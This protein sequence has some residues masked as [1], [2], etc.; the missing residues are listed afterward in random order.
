M[1]SC[2]LFTSYTKL[3]HVFNRNSFQPI[4]ISKK[5][6]LCFKCTQIKIIKIVNECFVSF[7]G[8]LCGLF[9]SDWC[10]W[11]FNLRMISYTLFM[12]DNMSLLSNSLNWNAI[13]SFRVKYL[14][15]IKNTQYIFSTTFA[16]HT[17]LLLLFLS[18]LFFFL[19]FSLVSFYVIRNILEL[20]NVFNGLNICTST[21]SFNLISFWMKWLQQYNLSNKFNRKMKTISIFF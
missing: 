15:W 18:F 3:V 12:T 2:F 9:S 7:L 11:T 6:K 14:K 1:L 13:F 4:K 5:K 20:S 17:L 16:G 8:F 21:T 10:N 19:L